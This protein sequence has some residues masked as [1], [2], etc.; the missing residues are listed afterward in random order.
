MDLNGQR[1]FPGI[2]L[3]GFGL[4]FFL[5]QSAFTWVKPYLGWPALLLITGISFLVQGL[6]EEGSGILPG[7]VLTGFGLHFY[8]VDYLGWWANDTGVFILIIAVG[9]L[10]QHQKTG[11]GLL[12]GILFLFLAAITLF[13]GTIKQWLGPLESFWQFWPLVLIAIGGYLLFVQK[14]AGHSRKKS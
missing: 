7:V 8:V 3:I 4:Y 2:L 6:K 10:L 13:Y 11:H 14:N 1:M 5:Q 12:N 9:F